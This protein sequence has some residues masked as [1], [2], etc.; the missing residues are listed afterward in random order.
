MQR[1]VS[2]VD[3]V[4]RVDRIDRTERTGR[5]PH[6]AIRFAPAEPEPRVVVVA[7]PVIPKQPSGKTLAGS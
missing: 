3:R 1:R 4:A 7:S 2:R 6:T 5:N